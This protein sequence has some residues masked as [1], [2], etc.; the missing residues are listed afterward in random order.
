MGGTRGGEEGAK[1]KNPKQRESGQRDSSHKNVTKGGDRSKGG[2][3]KK[4]SKNWTG[5]R[6]ML[7][8]PATN[9]AACAKASL[10]K[11]PKGSK[12]RNQPVWGSNVGSQ[13]YQGG[14]G[15]TDKEGGW[16]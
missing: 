2:G 9:P 3:K 7:A 14:G 10:G 1:R 16:P 12:S 15:K 5:F 8:M 13:H 11:G 4:I 6:T